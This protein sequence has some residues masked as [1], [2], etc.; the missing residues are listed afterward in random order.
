MQ[1]HTTSASLADVP[2][3]DIFWVVT[4]RS[5]H[6]FANYYAIAQGAMEDA[7]VGQALLHLASLHPLPS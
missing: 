1:A 4:W 7:S 3:H 6:M 5:M 2:W